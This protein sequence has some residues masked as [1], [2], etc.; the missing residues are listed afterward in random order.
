MNKVII[1]Q[2][3]EGGIAIFYPAPQALTQYTLEAIAGA[4]VPV[5]VPYQI[6]NE[7]DI[8][9]DRAYRNAWEFDIQNPDGVGAAYSTM[10]GVQ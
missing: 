9:A 4:V 7:S 5:G 2:K 8:P 10:D 1:Y 3:P 6:V